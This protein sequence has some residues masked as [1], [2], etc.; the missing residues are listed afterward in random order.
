[1]SNI[2][3]HAAQGLL[4][5]VSLYLTLKC[6][7][8]RKHQTRDTPASAQFLAAALGGQQRQAP[9]QS[10]WQTSP[11]QKTLN[12]PAATWQP[13]P[14]PSPLCW[15]HQFGVP[16]THANLALTV[17]FTIPA[18]QSTRKC[19]TA[20]WRPFFDPIVWWYPHQLR[21]VQSLRDQSPSVRP[22][23]VAT[24]TMTTFSALTQLIYCSTS[25]A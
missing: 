8:P 10:A 5:Q 1:M 17:S 11:R 22:F 21:C 20:I 4:E 9:A 14:R 16:N 25:A 3:R 19:L 15:S 13:C 18:W 6:K 12:C 7:P 23:L 24:G 2:S